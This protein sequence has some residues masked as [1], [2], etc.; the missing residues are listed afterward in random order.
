MGES[1]QPTAAEWKVLRIVSELQNCAAREVCDVAAARHQW[2]ASTVKTLLRRLVDK[3]HLRTKRVGN[4]F[5]YRPS[6]SALRSLKRAAD[7]LLDNAAEGT[8][9]PLIAYMVKK[10]R[11]S[12]DELSELRALLDEPEDDR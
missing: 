6:R 11:L 4:S 5:L 8:V 1:D 9:A 3:G 2:S 7:A 12:E 10:S